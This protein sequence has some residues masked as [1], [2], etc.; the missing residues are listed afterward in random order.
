M[1]EETAKKFN[2]QPGPSFHFVLNDIITWDNRIPPRGFNNEKFK[3]RLCGPVGVEY[4]DSQHWHVTEFDM[5]KGTKKVIVKLMYQSMSWEYLKF[6]V[7]ENRTDNLG[8]TLFETW[9]KTGKCKP[10]VMAEIETEI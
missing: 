2:K 7:E 6:L 3:E 9:E 4:A 8:N 10:T 1:S 5:P